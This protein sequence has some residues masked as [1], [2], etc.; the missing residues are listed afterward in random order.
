MLSFIVDKPEAVRQ[1]PFF[2]DTQLIYDPKRTI[3][4]VSTESHI[5]SLM[6]EQV[7]RYVGPRFPGDQLSAPPQPQPQPQP[8]PRFPGMLCFFFI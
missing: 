6:G 1:V 5:G 2:S 7:P 4:A 3:S 8:Q